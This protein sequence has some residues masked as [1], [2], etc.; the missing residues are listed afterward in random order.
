[1]KFKRTILGHIALLLFFLIFTGCEIEEHSKN[2][3]VAALKEIAAE[4]VLIINDRSWD[5]LRALSSDE[6]KNK[7]DDDF[8]ER[9]LYSFLNKTGRY[10]FTRSIFFTESA[11]EKTGEKVGIII[12]KTKYE[13]KKLTYTFNFNERNELI[14]FFIQ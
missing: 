1:M 14:G 9:N 5:E 3:N 11:E 12:V 10:K 6:F 7:F 13:Y 4:M 2:F 8:I